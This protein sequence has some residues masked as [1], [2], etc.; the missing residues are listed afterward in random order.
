MKVK[1]YTLVCVCFFN[2]NINVSALHTAKHTPRARL[3]KMKQVFPILL[4]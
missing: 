1:Q 3:Y 2:R 4:I